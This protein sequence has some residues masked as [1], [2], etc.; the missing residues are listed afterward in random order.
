MNNTT[1]R[2]LPEGA[3]EDAG[4]E[5]PRQARDGAEAIHDVEGQDLVLL[6]DESGRQ[7]VAAL[8]RREQNDA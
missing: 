7:G 3:G 2:L 4:H 5:E 1:I 6:S 8:V